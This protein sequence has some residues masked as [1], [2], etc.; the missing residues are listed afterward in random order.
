MC[1]RLQTGW[2]H[3]RGEVQG[4]EAGLSV[5]LTRAVF[6]KVIPPTGSYACEGWGLRRVQGRLKRDL[7][8]V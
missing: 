7:A 5:S 1:S 8:Q 2:E 4:I 6:Q 3:L